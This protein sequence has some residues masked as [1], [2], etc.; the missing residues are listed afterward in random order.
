MFSPSSFDIEYAKK[1]L[2][3]YEEAQK[4]GLG[5][6]S[7][8]GKMIDKPIIERAMRVIAKAKRFG[9]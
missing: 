7:L 1:V 4:V 9:L 2:L 6:F 5:V 3:G 8:E